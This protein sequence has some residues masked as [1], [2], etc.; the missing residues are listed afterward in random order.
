MRATKR[1]AHGLAVALA[2][3]GIVTL[4]TDGC[5]DFAVAAPDRTVVGK[6]KA[7]F[8]GVLYGSASDLKTSTKQVFSQNS[9]GTPGTAEVGHRFGSALTTAD[10]DR[11]GYTDLVVASGSARATC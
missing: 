9:A 11:N 6:A 8:V 7:G 4:P 3:G 10:L 5:A 1:V 2:L